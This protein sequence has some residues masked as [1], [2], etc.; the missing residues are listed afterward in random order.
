MPVMNNAPAM[1]LIRHNPRDS[2]IRVR[3]SIDA[4]IAGAFAEALARDVRTLSGG[5]DTI[6]LDFEELE[7]DDG[8]SIAQMVNALRELG[9]DAHVVVRHAP[10]MLAHTL[11]KAG[12]L[13][14]AWLSLE[15]P[16]QEEG[17][18]G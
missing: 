11:Y 1:L 17:L 7:L 13:R 3:G 10:Q 14:A 15:D 4:S 16:R 5:G 9:R 6:H 2:D 12:L 8:V 18:A